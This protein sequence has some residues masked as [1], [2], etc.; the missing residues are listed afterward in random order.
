MGRVISIMNMKGGVGKTTTALALASA[1]AGNGKK[2]LVIDADDSANPSLTKNLV[3][4][5]DGEGKVTLTNI[6]LDRITRKAGMNASETIPASEAVH[7]HEEGFDYIC[8]DNRLPGITA[9][10]FGF[11]ETGQ[12]PYILKDVT[13]ELKGTYDY[14]ILDAAPALNMMSTNILTAT[15]DVII[16]TQA[17]GA[18]EDGIAELI[19]SAKTVKQNTNASLV[20]RGLLITMVD[21]RTKYNKNKAQDMQSMY[22]DLG[23]SVFDTQIP[24]SVK[25]E[26]YV[27]R[28]MSVIGYDPRGKVAIAY[29]R[30]ADEYL[31]KEAQR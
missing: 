26:E 31:A 9:N 27:E 17:Q 22:R 3:K 12:Q 25:A 29:G 16:A 10:G 4:E 15:D 18:S 30:F 19:G 13:D 6:L 23:L 11:I 14:I 8:A 5:E 21:A 24:R 1:F 20:I 28:G 2:V 7:R